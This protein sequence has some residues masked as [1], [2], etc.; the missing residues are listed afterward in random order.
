[1]TIRE[2][3]KRQEPRIK[4]KSAN[5]FLIVFIVTTTGTNK[6]K[7]FFFRFYNIVT[8]QLGID[9]KVKQLL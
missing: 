6:T 2:S 9:R 4:G 3:V 7:Y 1:M 5:M 8:L